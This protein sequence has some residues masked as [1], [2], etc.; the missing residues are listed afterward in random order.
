MSKK[1]KKNY[2]YEPEDYAPMIYTS[3]TGELKSATYA[4]RKEIERTMGKDKDVVSSFV[5]VSKS[6]TLANYN[7]EKISL[8][9][10]VAVVAVIIVT[11]LAA[12]VIVSLIR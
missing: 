4:L 9:K 5:K 11:I 8:M 7:K 10:N 2:N 3:L 12:A 1:D 6:W